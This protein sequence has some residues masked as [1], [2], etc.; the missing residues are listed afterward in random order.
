MRIDIVK[1]LP[2]PFVDLAVDVSNG[3]HLL[4]VPFDHGGSGHTR[5][6]PIS[7]GEF[8]E[9]LADDSS[10]DTLLRNGA[11]GRKIYYSTFAADN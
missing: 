3:Q 4:G 9:F 5:Y 8:A 6:Y 7:D 1:F 11:I 2:R 10:V